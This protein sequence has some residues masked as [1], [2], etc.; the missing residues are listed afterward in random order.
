M[1]KAQDRQKSYEKLSRRP[2]EFIEGFH[3]FLK[4][5]PKLGLKGLFKIKMLS[6][7]YIGPYQITTQVGE[8]AYKM[9]FILP[10]SGLQSVFH[11]SQ[12]QKFVLDHFH[13]ILLY[14]IEVVSYLTFQPQPSRV[15]D[16]VVK[17]LRNKEISLVKV[18]WEDILVLI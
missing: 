8:V 17:S 5:T 4:V 6:Q 16:Y 2:L 13:P 10:V 12:L 18:L 11:V 1:K 15:V 14:T 9:E 3:M 7:K